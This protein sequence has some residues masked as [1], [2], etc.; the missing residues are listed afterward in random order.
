MASIFPSSLE[1]IRH[2]AQFIIFFILQWSKYTFGMNL[3]TQTLNFQFPAYMY[4]WSLS[5][6]CCLAGQNTV[7]ELCMC[8]G[9][10]VLN[11]AC[12]GTSFLASFPC[13]QSPL[14]AFF[15]CLFFFQH[16]KKETG[17]GTG[18]EA[19]SCLHIIIPFSLMVAADNQ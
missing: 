9:P 15:A 6:S 4:T 3:K 8:V 12:F 14:S 11:V 16:A 1:R 10:W 17:S 5:S 18:N 2:R 19:D 7:H 13:S